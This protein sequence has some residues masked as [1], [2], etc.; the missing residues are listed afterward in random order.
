[1][2]RLIFA[3]LSVTHWALAL[4]LHKASETEL[5]AQDIALLKN[6]IAKVYD[7]LVVGQAWAILDPA[8]VK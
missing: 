4:R 2:L 3:P 6:L 5:T 8:S 7:P 1:M